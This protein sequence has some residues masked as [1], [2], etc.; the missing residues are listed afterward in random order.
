MTIALVGRTG[1]GKS[2]ATKGLIEPELTVGMR[3]CVIDPTGAWWGLRLRPDGVTPAFAVVIF[4]GDHADVP[5]TSD[6]GEPLAEVVLDGRAVQSVIDISD[7]SGSEQTRFLTAFFERL[8]ARNRSP[9]TLVMDEADAYCP[10]NP[11]PEQRRL[12]GSVNKIVR[13]GRI[14]GFR[15][16]MITQRPAVLDKSVLSQIDTLIAMRLTSP[17]DRKAIE[18]WV[19]GNAD[20]GQAKEV[21]DS[22][23]SLPRGEGWYWAP[24]DDVLERRTFPLIMTFDSSRTPERGETLREVAP[25][26]LADIDGLRAAFLPAEASQSP[27]TPSQVK[28]D[29]G[30]ATL[31][32][33]IARLGKKVVELETLGHEEIPIWFR[34]GFEAGIGAARKAFDAIDAVATINLELDVWRSTGAIAQEPVAASTASSLPSQRRAKQAMAPKVAAARGNSAGPSLTGPQRQFLKALAWWRAMG[35]DDPSRAQVAAIAGWRITSGHL[36]NVAGSLSSL[37]LIRY[38]EPGVFAFT[39]AGAHAAPEPDL[40]ATLHD[41]LR[42]TFTGPQQKAFDALLGARKNLPRDDFAKRCGWEPTSGHVKNVL[43]SLSTLEVVYYPRAGEVALQKWV[44]ET[45]SER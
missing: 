42:A 19:K 24:H 40:G 15:P 17:Q 5:I 1:S 7:M 25:T 21:L 8:Y 9:L 37:G 33:E 22:L 26:A 39:D 2:Y 38:P 23:A 28:S 6:Q 44:T 30:D 12:Q 41:S 18:E 4:G 14:K 27:K 29:V 13:R 45:A 36:K 34:R 20:V 10:Q 35:H 32:A 3:V 31:R 43:G 16:I 11:L